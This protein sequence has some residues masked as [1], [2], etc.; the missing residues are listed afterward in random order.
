VK[1]TVLGFEFWGLGLFGFDLV[2]FCLVGLF[3]VGL[4]LGWFGL[5]GWSD[6]TDHP[7]ILCI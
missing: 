2:W 4:V 5:F 6:M 3:G 7:C 1:R